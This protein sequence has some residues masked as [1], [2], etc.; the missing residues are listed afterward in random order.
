MTSAFDPNQFLGAVLTSANTRRQPIPA[1]TNLPGTL[2]TPST[3]QTEGKKESNQGVVYTWV[4]IP[5][6]VDLTGN[7]PVRTLVGQDHVQLRYSFRLDVSP[8]GGID[9]SPGKNNGLRILREAVGMNKDGESFSLLGVGGRQV[10][11]SIGN[12]PYQGEIFDE[13]ASIARLG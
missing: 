11:C 4:D 12:R 3:R 6:E 10:L 7:P 5:I 2:G 9:L 1:G 13:I 8:S